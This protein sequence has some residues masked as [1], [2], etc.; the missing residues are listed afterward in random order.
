MATLG[1]RGE[2]LLCGELLCVVTPGHHDGE[3]GAVRDPELF[4]SIMEVDFHGSLADARLPRDLLVRQP[5]VTNLAISRSRSVSSCSI[6]MAH[7]PTPSV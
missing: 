5:A 3:H 4:V 2:L 6:M 7:L 1:L